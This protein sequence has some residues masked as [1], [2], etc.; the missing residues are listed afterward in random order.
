MI[1]P[2]VE[3]VL[4]LKFGVVI[5][6]TATCSPRTDTHTQTDRQTKLHAPVCPL[7]AYSHYDLINSYAHCV[8]EETKGFQNAKDIENPSQTTSF[9]KKNPVF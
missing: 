9:L 1:L 4:N 6:K 7:T 5:S 3:A 8:C 2:R